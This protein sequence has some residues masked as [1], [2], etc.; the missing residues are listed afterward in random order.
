MLIYCFQSEIASG[1]LPT[2]PDPQPFVIG[3][4]SP[5]MLYFF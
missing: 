2:T 4:V 5:G 1:N 3:S